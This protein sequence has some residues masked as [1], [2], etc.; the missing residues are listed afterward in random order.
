MK[1][2]QVNP[3]T[4][5]SVQHDLSNMEP[6]LREIA[7]TYKVLDDLLQSYGNST[8]IPAINEYRA[9]LRSQVGIAT[10]NAEAIASATS[11]FSIIL[12][13]LSKE[14]SRL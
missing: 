12:K 14:I 9:Q 4:N 6:V 3:A 10:E 1:F 2:Y 13:E 11:K 8:D 7:A 5:D